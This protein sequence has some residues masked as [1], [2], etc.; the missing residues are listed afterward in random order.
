MLLAVQVSTRTDVPFVLDVFDVLD[1]AREWATP[2]PEDESNVRHVP[3]DRGTLFSVSSFLRT[4]SASSSSANQK[5][6][7]FKWMYKKKTSENRL[8]H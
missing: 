5:L 3:E 1:G 6:D 7:I 2:C 8:H 4:P